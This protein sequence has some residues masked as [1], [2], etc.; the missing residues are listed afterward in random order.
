MFIEDDIQD[1]Y[2]ES[3]WGT[4]SWD[5]WDDLFLIWQEFKGL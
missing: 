5:T 3:Y 4:T 2:F 1:A